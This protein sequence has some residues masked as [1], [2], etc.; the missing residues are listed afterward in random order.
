MHSRGI[1]HRDLKPSN[2]LLDDN[3]H[4]KLVDFGCSKFEA[5][6]KKKKIRSSICIEME[7]KDDYEKTMDLKL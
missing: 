1:C 4:L 2:M 7:Q 5:V 6:K 3:Y